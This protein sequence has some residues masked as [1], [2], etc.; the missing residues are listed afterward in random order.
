MASPS[1]K[2]GYTPIANE[3]LEQVYKLKLNGTQFRILLVVW[4]FTYGFSRAEC[5]LSLKFI[6]DA[7]QMNK[8]QVQREI[9]ALITKNIIIVI[10]EADF[11]KPRVVA[12]NKD[13]GKWRDS[14]QLANLLTDNKKANNTVSEV[15]IPVVSEIANQENNTKT[16]FKTKRPT[17]HKYGEYKK[18]LL[19]DEQKERLINELGQS[20]FEKCVKKLDEYMQETGKRYSDHNLTI[21]RWVIKAVAQEQGGETYGDKYKTDGC[22]ST[23]YYKQFTAQ[24]DAN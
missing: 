3:L 18:V 2:N 20:T 24:E 17:K 6:A 22:D 12:F 5:K 1:I 23:D 9:D 13:Y 8:M 15:V 21:R 10:S 19:T 4:R 11:N 14:K 7:T 16:K